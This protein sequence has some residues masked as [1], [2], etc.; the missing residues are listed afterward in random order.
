MLPAGVNWLTNVQ[1][2]P[3]PGEMST[4]TRALTGT[5]RALQCTALSVQSPASLDG[6]CSA[7]V[8]VPAARSSNVGVA[9]TWVSGA[10]VVAVAVPSDG[11][12][13]SK[14]NVPTP[15]VV[16]FAMVNAAGGGW[17]SSVNVHVTTSPPTRCTVA[18]ALAGSV[19]D[20]LVPAAAQVRL[21]SCQPAG[22]FSLKLQSLPPAR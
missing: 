1:S 9:V 17:N 21:A 20:V 5:G 13:T 22:T 2:V 18:A 7:I 10:V 3:C 14:R 19:V 15:P 4:L 12:E 8:Y 16:T 11:P 6:R